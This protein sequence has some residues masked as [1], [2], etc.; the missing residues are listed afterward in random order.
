MATRINA[1]GTG[2]AERLA[3][4]DERIRRWETGE[5]RWPSPVYRRAL[6]ELTGLEP[7]E[8]GFL[9]HDSHGQGRPGALDTLRAE[10]EFFNT[11]E[12]ARMV[13]VSD[14]GEGTAEALQEAADLLCRAYPSAPAEELRVRTRQRLKYLA[15]L[16]GGRLTL[17]QH[18]DLLVTA[19]WLWLLL[20]CLHFDLGE[21]EPA[22]T[23]RQAA[24]QIGQQTGSGQV[25]AWA[26]EMAAWFALTEGR[27]TD[28]IDYSRAGQQLAGVSHAMVQLV[29]QEARGR[30]RLGQR[31]EVRASLG[32]GT[33]LLE[34]F[35]RP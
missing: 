24:Y 7:A 17:R 14:I 23:A 8:L 29:L 1:T 5:V 26:C 34:R 32:R 33:N 31:R 30:A 2:V 9:P 25:A 13:T 15:Q 20:G 4:D 35:P 28:V 16:L 11:M 19:G 22:E 18:R 6:S 12:L 3:C 10:A 21:R 27:Y